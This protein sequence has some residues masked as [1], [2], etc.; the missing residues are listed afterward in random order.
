MV[1]GG[2]TYS[3]SLLDADGRLAITVTGAKR[4]AR[5]AQMPNV[6]ASDSRLY[7]LDGDGKV[8]FV[9]PNGAKGVATTIP[10]DSNSVAAF[11]VSPDNSRIAVAIITIPFPA[12]TR[13]YVEDLAGGG[14][15]VELYSS[16]EVMEWPLAWRQG[17]LVL[18]IGINGAPQNTGEWFNYGYRGYHVVDAGT[19][20]R[21]ATVC[22]GNDAIAPPV[23]AG[24]ACVGSSGHVISDWSGTTRAAPQDD[25]CGGGALSPNGSLVAICQGNPRGVVIVSAAGK[26]TTTGIQADPEGWIDQTHLVVRSDKDGSLIVLDTQTDQPTVL[27]AQGFFAGTLPGGL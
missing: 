5:W 21:V 27:Q 26:T 11:S 15:H 24:T 20:A 1:T 10:V 19:G 18:G 12:K 25:G 3:A 23:P 13:I 17:N 14:H 6:S 7:Y 2:S 9:A 16:S 4:T 22:D 8:M